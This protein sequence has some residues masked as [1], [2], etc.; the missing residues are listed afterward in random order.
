MKLINLVAILIMSLF[1]VACGGG[2]SGSEPIAPVVD[3]PIIIDDGGDDDDDEEEIDPNAVYATTAE[4]KATKSFLLKQEYELT[5]SYKNASNRNA[6]LSVCTEFTE[7]E[8][9]IKVN[10]NTCLLRTS[11]DKSYTGS[12][13]V[14]ND[15]NRLVMAIWYFDDVKSPR[16]EVWENNSD[17]E[18]ERKFDVN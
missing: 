9:G 13:I 7:G 12:L 2:S 18:G 14:A 16:Y 4:L 5:V 6:Y 8:Y 15:K 1:I 11:I 10:Y 17:A 3:V